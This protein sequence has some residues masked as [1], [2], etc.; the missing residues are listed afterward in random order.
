MVGEFIII[1][2]AMEAKIYEVM[3]EEYPF[4]GRCAA[5]LEEPQEIIKRVYYRCSL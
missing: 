4:G 2:I 5:D 1:I 3:E